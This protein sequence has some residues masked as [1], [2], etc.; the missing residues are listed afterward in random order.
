MAFQF[1][2]QSYYTDFYSRCPNKYTLEFKLYNVDIILY[3][4]LHRKRFLVEVYKHL[5]GFNRFYKVLLYW[6]ICA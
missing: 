2:N 5:I 1:L 3:K 4:L 6:A